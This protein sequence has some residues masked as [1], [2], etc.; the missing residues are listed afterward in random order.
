MID[1]PYNF[2]LDTGVEWLNFA[3]SYQ[4]DYGVAC[5]KGRAFTSR[6]FAH[7]ARYTREIYWSGFQRVLDIVYP[8]NITSSL[9]HALSWNCTDTRESYP[10]RSF[11][12]IRQPFPLKM[13]NGFTLLIPTGTRGESG[14]WMLLLYFS[15]VAQLQFYYF[16][17]VTCV[18]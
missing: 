13:I 18:Y 15:L 6:L 4:L 9:H 8:E 7:D 1:D 17:S 16:F 14:Q 3:C 2:A 5:S 11:E 10:L 12:E